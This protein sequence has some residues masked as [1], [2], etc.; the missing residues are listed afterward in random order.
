LITKANIAK[1]PKP[2][3]AQLKR[4]ELFQKKLSNAKTVEVLIRHLSAFPKDSKV[5]FSG[6]DFSRLKMRGDFVQV[7]F[8][9]QVYLNNRGKIII[10]EISEE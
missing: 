10:E 6:L 1:P 7:E 4:E 3:K 9:Q 5:Y 2:T 8:A